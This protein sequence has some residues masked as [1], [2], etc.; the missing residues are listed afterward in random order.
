MLSEISVSY[1][2]WVSCSQEDY[3]EGFK[4]RLLLL[5]LLILLVL[6]MDKE[7]DSVLRYVILP[8]QGMIANEPLTSFLGFISCLSV[9]LTFLILLISYFL[10]T[11]CCTCFLFSFFSFLICPYFLALS[12]FA[13]N[14]YLIL[15][16]LNLLNLSFYS[17]I[18]RLSSI[19]CILKELISWLRFLRRLDC[20]ETCFYSYF[21]SLAFFL[22]YFI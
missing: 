21:C 3:E 14:S 11:A 19:F 4:G 16:L 6:L 17:F 15:L 13:S 1:S 10:F 8:A 22:S 7:V 18:F 5:L 2:S 9:S 20:S 12:L